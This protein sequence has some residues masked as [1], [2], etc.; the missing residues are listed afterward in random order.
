MTKLYRGKRDPRFV[1]VSRGGLLED[2]LHQSLAR[3]G[4]VCAERV[5]PLFEAANPDDP[6]PRQAVEAARLWADGKI[7]MMQARGYAVAAHAA[8]RSEDGEAKAAARAAGHAVASA[9]MA[10]HA[11][12]AAY[13]ALKAME[14][15]YPDESAWIETEKRWQIE[16]LTEDIRELVVDD[17]RLRGEKFRGMF[18]PG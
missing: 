15:A 6:R 12:G 17:M 1:R 5:L 10:D 4:A 9:H 16:A 7:T 3:W 18:D 11:L 8:A 14:A 13:Y 2:A